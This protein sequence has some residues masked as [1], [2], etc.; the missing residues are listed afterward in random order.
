MERLRRSPEPPRKDTTYAAVKRAGLEGRMTLE[1]RLLG[2]ILGRAPSVEELQARTP[3]D[4]ARIREKEVEAHRRKMAQVFGTIPKTPAGEFSI[5]RSS[6]S[7][8]LSRLTEREVTVL[9][10][11]FGLEDGKP[12]TLREVGNVIGRSPSTVRRV[13]REAL[14]NLRKP[15]TQV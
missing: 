12:R 4:I 11:R 3:E 7:K 14:A 2:E 5:I 6:V 10:L 15:Q 9:R 13:E 8:A 1:E